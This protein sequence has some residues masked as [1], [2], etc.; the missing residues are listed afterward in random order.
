VAGW[1]ESVLA[2]FTADF[3]NDGSGDT[4]SNGGDAGEH[5]ELLTLG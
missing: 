2:G 5:D 1:W 4:D 3:A